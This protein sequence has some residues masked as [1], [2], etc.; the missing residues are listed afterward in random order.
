MTCPTRVRFLPGD[1]VYIDDLDSYALI[2]CVVKDYYG[3]FYRAFTKYEYRFEKKSN[4]NNWEHRAKYIEPGQPVN[5]YS[6]KL[7]DRIFFPQRNYICQEDRCA[8]KSILGECLDCKHKIDYSKKDANI[9][10]PGDIV[11][12]PGEKRTA[13]VAAMCLCIPNPKYPNAYITIS[14]WSSW[15]Y[16]LL[17]DNFSIASE[18]SAIS[19]DRL[20]EFILGNSDM[21]PKITYFEESWKG[22]LGM[23]KIPERARMRSQSKIAYFIP[24][25]AGSIC[26]ACILQ[27]SYD[28]VECK[29]KKLIEE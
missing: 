4:D 24:E 26:S 21:P 6:L 11:W 9:F 8:V 25:D 15:N 14:P 3:V 18:E 10:L 20:Y 7:I 16:N 27:D 2:V 12:H 22:N 5:N 28:C 29:T 1:F 23:A 19:I 13:E 17:T